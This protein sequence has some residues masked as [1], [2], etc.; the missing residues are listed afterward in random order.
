M[1][2][3]ETMGN[4]L[5]GAGDSLFGAGTSDALLSA[6]GAALDLVGGPGAGLLSSALGGFLGGDSASSAGGGAGLSAALGAGGAGSDEAHVANILSMARAQGDL[7]SML[8]GGAAGA[9]MGGANLKWG[10]DSAPAAAPSHIGMSDLHS[11]YSK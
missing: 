4:E 8:L 11:A 3:F 6:G 7:D 5:A 10:G 1:S 2:I 9:S